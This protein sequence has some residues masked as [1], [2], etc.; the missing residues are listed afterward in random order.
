VH[1]MHLPRRETCDC[2]SL[3]RWSGLAQESGRC[4]KATAGRARIGVNKVACLDHQADHG[5]A[6]TRRGEGVEVES[7]GLYRHRKTPLW[8][9]SSVREERAQSGDPVAG[10]H[11]LRM[12][13]GYGEARV[14][15]KKI[16]LAGMSCRKQTPRSRTERP[17]WCPLRPRIRSRP[18]PR[19]AS[20]LE[21]ELLHQGATEGIRS[22]IVGQAVM[23]LH[24]DNFWGLA[25]EWGTGFFE[26]VQAAMH[27]HIPR[28]LLRC[29]RM[30]RQRL[31]G[32]FDPTHTSAGGTPPS[33]AIIDGIRGPEVSQR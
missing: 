33:G 11:L 17:S 10:P 6:K 29:S 30:H 23:A 13:Q 22:H 19:P 8:S 18:E 25:S 9:W 7:C 20:A 4:G 5:F 1:A 27:G 14:D 21:D 15:A 2:R 26:S 32:Q 16:D 3:R 31:L 12:S 24:R 28:H